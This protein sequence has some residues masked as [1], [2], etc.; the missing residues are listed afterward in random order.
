MPRGKYARKKREATHPCGICGKMWKYAKKAARCTE[1]CKAK[2]AV[3]N[4]G[5]ANECDLRALVIQMKT[6]M[7]ER[8]R[9]FREQITDLREE[10]ATLKAAKPGARESYKMRLAKPTNCFGAWSSS[11]II[12]GLAKVSEWFL[13]CAGFPLF[14]TTA[15]MIICHC[16]FV[17]NNGEKLVSLGSY[18]SDKDG[19]PLFMDVNTQQRWHRKISTDGANEKVYQSDIMPAWEEVEPFFKSQ[20]PDRQLVQLQKDWKGTYRRLN[21]LNVHGHDGQGWQERHT[22]LIAL[23]NYTP[24]EQQTSEDEFEELK[25]IE[26]DLFWETCDPEDLYVYDRQMQ[27]CEQYKKLLRAHL[28]ANPERREIYTMMGGK[29][30]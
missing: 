28:N 5:D 16:L 15:I 24:P 3:R 11:A 7:E 4:C 17:L 10:L 2:D 9:Y 13:G 1:T 6:Q 23:A 26:G 27:D 22:L 30:L 25:D 18:P 19:I 20:A 21:L 29:L 8:D 14:K 12:R